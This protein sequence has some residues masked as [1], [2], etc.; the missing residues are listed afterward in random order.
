MYHS[1]KVKVKIP[2]Y[3]QFQKLK[4]TF[5][6][7]RNQTEWHQLISSTVSELGRESVI[8]KVVFNMA[9]R[10]LRT[11]HSS[12]DMTSC[13]SLCPD[14]QIKVAFIATFQAGNQALGNVQGKS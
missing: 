14:I 2:L 7:F 1:K 11:T 9:Y 4:Y 3:P 5:I 12:A 6:Q 10:A 13:S 8:L